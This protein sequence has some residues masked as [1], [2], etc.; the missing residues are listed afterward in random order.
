M[1]RWQRER[2]FPLEGSQ[3]MAASQSSFDMVSIQRRC[4]LHDSEFCKSC[5]RGA[6]RRASG[7]SLFARSVD[8][9][10]CR[11]TESLPNSLPLSAPMFD[12]SLPELLCAS[13]HAIR[14]PKKPEC[15]TH[16]GASRLRDMDAK[17]TKSGHKDYTVLRASNRPQL[18]LGHHRASARKPGRHN[19][20]TTRMCSHP[21]SRHRFYSRLKRSLRI[22]ATSPFP[23]CA[24]HVLLFLRACAV[25]CF[26]SCVSRD[27]RCVFR[28]ALLNSR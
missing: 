8:R 19:A 21:L 4:A 14:L 24:Q 22:A 27:V 15:H 17:L 9:A 3:R 28:A 23:T 5:R 25:L 26:C 7:A 16:R 11:R 10:R 13:L 12:L 1:R 20:F 2:A 18:R 6:K